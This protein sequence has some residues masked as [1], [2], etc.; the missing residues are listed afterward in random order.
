VQA[1]FPEKEFEDL[2][3]T[4]KPERQPQ[5]LDEFMGAVSERIGAAMDAFAQCDRTRRPLRGNPSGRLTIRVELA[6]DGTVGQAGV[7]ENTTKDDWLAYCIV[8]KIVV[9]RFPKLIR[10]TEAFKIP[11]YFGPEVDNIGKEKKQKGREEPPDAGKEGSGQDQ[12]AL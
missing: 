11:I 6:R 1:K 3:G 7:E 4:E 8:K 2:P 5:G 9:M 12:P 10:A